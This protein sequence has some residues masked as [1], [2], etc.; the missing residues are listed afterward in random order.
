MA[1]AAVVPSTST[2]DLTSSTSVPIRLGASI[3][4]SSEDKRLT[5]IKYNYKP[6]V[7][8]G[9]KVESSFQPRDDSSFVLKLKNGEQEYRYRSSKRARTSQHDRYVLLAQGK[10]KDREVVLEKLDA[11]FDFN[12]L[13]L[14]DG[15]NVWELEDEYPHIPVDGGAGKTLAAEAT[16]HSEAGPP[17]AGNPFDYRHYM[18]EGAML[19]AQSDT[20]G[21][22]AER[23]ASPPRA[24]AGPATSRSEPPKHPD[25]ADKKRKAQE[26]VKSDPK[27]AKAS[28]EPA[29]SATKSKAPIPRVKLDR[30]ASLQVPP[31]EDSG[32]LVVDD[33]TPVTEKPRSA[34]ALAFS[35]QLGQGPIS[36]HSA[37]ASPLMSSR[38]ASPAVPRPGRY[39]EDEEMELGEES[40]DEEE[41]ADADVE[42]LELP[43]PAQAH[44]PGEEDGEHVIGDEEEDDDFT[45]QLSLALQDPGE[46]DVVTGNVQ[47]ESEESEEE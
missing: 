3:L 29:P 18:G 4:K 20:K 45:K 13:R 34:M 21:I 33:E 38:V 46:P 11:C 41:E 22:R 28:G 5:S 2:L 19:A 40:G 42:G 37:A 35:G 25:A 31:Y 24:R 17:E 16:Q 27:R 30:K 44:R 32:E 7:E 12:L 14:P 8:D 39:L 43:S 1:A 6:R 47:D 10:G 26:P 36:L 23:G 9:K 15:K